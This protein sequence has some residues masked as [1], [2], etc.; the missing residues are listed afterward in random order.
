MINF[1]NQCD[2]IIEDRPLGIVWDELS[3]WSKLRFEN[4]LDWS[5]TWIERTKLAEG[6]HSPL[7]ASWPQIQ[8]DQM[9]QVS[10]TD[11]TDKTH[12][13]RIIIDS[14]SPKYFWHDY[15]K[16][17]SNYQLFRCLSLCSIT[18]SKVVLHLSFL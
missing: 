1:D 4:F 5:L 18:L 2:R 11:A 7:F 8:C 16:S 12:K 3:W 13:L 14:S 15:S 10:F 17:N 6:K 9:F